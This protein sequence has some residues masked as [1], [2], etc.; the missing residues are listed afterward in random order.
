[1]ASTVLEELTCMLF[2]SNLR[3]TLIATSPSTPSRSTARYTLL[4]APSPIFSTN[5]HFSRPGYLGN[6]FRLSFSS[7]TSLAI[8]SPSTRLLFV[9]AAGVAPALLSNA[10]AASRG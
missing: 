7:A 8:W 3:T 5:S 4:K 6:L 1:M 9:L 2:I 10:C